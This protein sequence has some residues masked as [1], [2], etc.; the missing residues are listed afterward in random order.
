[1]HVMW[2]LILFFFVVQSLPLALGAPTT[3]G[4]FSSLAISVPEIAA[5]A[6]GLPSPDREAVLH[7]VE[8]P[9]VDCCWPYRVWL[10]RK[11]RSYVLGFGTYVEAEVAWSPDSSAFFV[12]YS[13]GGAV[14]TFHVL[15]YRVDD[16]GPRKSEPI[17]D[18]RKLYKSICHTTEFPNVGAIQWGVDSTT[19]LIA[20]EV[21]PHSNCA[22]M[23]T[24][25][26]FEIALPG[27]KVLRTY[28]QLEAK[29]QFG[30]SLGRE[31]TN[32]DDE[33]VRKPEACVPPG[34]ELPSSSK[35]RTN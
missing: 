4:N 16:R 9:N 32:A 28:G 11:G 1:V 5:R 35:P 20:V 6:Q 22:S 31:L 15:V 34:L 7:A 26:A 23:G 21:Q 8:D 27:G 25:R 18:G 19:L 29:K 10:T 2:R 24:F 30:G 13:D 12:T 17:P 33:C 3:L 14:G